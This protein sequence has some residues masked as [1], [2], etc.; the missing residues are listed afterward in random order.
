[1]DTYNELARRRFV[2]QGNHLHGI[3]EDYRM[4]CGEA[5]KQASF[6]CTIKK[7]SP[8]VQVLDTK[9]TKAR[10]QAFL[11]WSEHQLLG[12]HSGR[13]PGRIGTHCNW[14]GY[15][16][17]CP[18]YKGKLHVAQPTKLTIKGKPRD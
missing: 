13:Y 6:H 1:M 3:W 4:T 18:W 10:I 2:W 7:A 8:E 17:R 5:I 16:H 14:C 9:I 15:Q 11:A 12:I